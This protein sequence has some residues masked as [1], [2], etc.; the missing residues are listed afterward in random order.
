LNQDSGGSDR[1][2]GHS[3]GLGPESPSSGIL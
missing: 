1:S 2:L 3:I